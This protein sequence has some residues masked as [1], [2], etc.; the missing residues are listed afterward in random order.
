MSIAARKSCKGK[1]SIS[2][3][4]QRPGRYILDAKYRDSQARECLIQEIKKN[5][6][7]MPK[8][9]KVLFERLVRDLESKET[10]SPAYG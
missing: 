5:L 9:T 2:P 8:T 4:E 3:R 6:D 1:I 10:D 7:K